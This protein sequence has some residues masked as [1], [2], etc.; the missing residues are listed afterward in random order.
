MAV[1]PFLIARAP[2]RKGVVNALRS[3]AA[4][5]VEVRSGRSLLLLKRLGRGGSTALIPRF[6][7]WLIC[8]RG[9]RNGGGSCKQLVRSF[10]GMLTVYLGVEKQ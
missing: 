8:S 4:A 5:V 3:S 7:T 9:M 2:V 6:G 1:M 10:G